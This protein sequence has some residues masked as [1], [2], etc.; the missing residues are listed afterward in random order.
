MEKQI[1]P[2][3]EMSCAVC[4]AAVEKTVKELPGVQEATVNFSANTIQVI[5][6]SHQISLY[7]M[8]AAVQ[9]A[10]YDLVISEHAE[11]EAA[12]AEKQHYLTLR[13]RTLGAWCFGLPVMILSMYF[14]QPSQGIMFLLLALTIPVLYWGRSFYISGWKAVRQGRANMD[15]LVMLSTS[16]SFL[17]SLFTTIYPSFWN[18]LGLLPH[19][20]YEAVVMIIV[21][22][23]T[24]KLLE[25]KAKQ[26]TSA[27]IRSLMELQP[28]T[29]RLIQA[30]GTEQDVPI[31]MLRP[32]NRVS[33]R[34]GEK[35]PVDGVV[36]NGGSFV[37]ESMISGESE[38]VEKAIG[39][40]VLAGTLNQRGAFTLEVKASGADTVLARMVRLVQEAQGSKAPVQSVVDRVSAIFVPTVIALSLLTFILWMIWAG[41]DDF[42]HALL[43]AISVLVIACPCA[44]GLAT[45]TALTV[46]IGRA[47][48][49]HI[50]IKDAFALENMCRVNTIVLDKTGTLTEGKPQV[51]DEKRLPEFEQFAPILLAAELRSEHPLAQALSE[52]LKQQNITPVEITDFE[53]ITGKGVTCS[54]QGKTFWAGNSSLAKLYTDISTAPDNYSI[55]F[56]RETQLLAAFEVRD[57]L[58]KNS[59]EAVRQLHNAGIEVYMLSGDK[60]STVTEIARQAG[61][62]HFHWEFLP[63][64]KERFIT[65][66]QQHGKCV[67]MVGDGINDSQSLARA[68][69][70]VAMG[71]GTDVAMNVAM[72]TLMNSDLALL[73]EA[74][75][76]SR[77]TVRIIR[78]N[79]FWAFGYNV[80]CIPIAAGALFPWGILLT[81]MW[82]SA[83]MAFSSVSVIL[84][85]LR[86]R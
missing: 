50:L 39:D 2:V 53:S 56:G 18:T 21:F 60:E 7:D 58:K 40:N 76:L 66:L 12:D 19:L 20:Y 82:A 74:V 27:S 5:Y 78:E 44:L 46:G 68:D 80:I 10:G 9:A 77:R 41:W 81:P 15:T 71:H 69:V 1:I 22:V 11:E 70:S 6:D 42:P 86:L 32:G 83:A 59:A 79:L 57:A 30:D 48:Q 13:Q 3:L 37:D 24:G 67:A 29:A 28:K 85:S 35:I 73:P 4:A 64:D 54:Y 14:H 17:F 23:L 8:R 72:V 84:N 26:S 43:S 55:Y 62:T 75:K 38:A 34:P 47:A 33:V 31:G 63:N 36:I 49:Q 65:S 25:A 16:V 45:P 61:I 52:Y 51:I